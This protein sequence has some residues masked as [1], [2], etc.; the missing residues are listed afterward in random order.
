MIAAPA[1]KNA[2]GRAAARPPALF[3]L[4]SLTSRSG[5][6][7]PL[8]RDTAPEVSDPELRADCAGAVPPRHEITFHRIKKSRPVFRLEKRNSR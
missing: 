5:L 6:S 3:P 2:G 1:R 8:V 4:F 7:R